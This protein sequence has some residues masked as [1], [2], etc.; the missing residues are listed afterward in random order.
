MNASGTPRR[1]PDALL[2]LAG[3]AVA[4]CVTLSL[5]AVSIGND[6]DRPAADTLVARIVEVLVAA[7]LLVAAAVC[8]VVERRLTRSGRLVAKMEAIRPT[9]RILAVSIAVAFLVCA[10]S[11]FG[12]RGILPVVRK[13][14]RAAWSP[15]RLRG[16]SPSVPMPKPWTRLLIPATACVLVEL[17]PTW[18]EAI[19]REARLRSSQSRNPQPR[20]RG[21]A[22][23]VVAYSV[24]GVASGMP[25][26]VNWKLAPRD[27]LAMGIT[28]VA[29]S[30]MFS[31]FSIVRGAAACGVGGIELVVSVVFAI[32]G[33]IWAICTLVLHLPLRVFVILI[34]LIVVAALVA[35]LAFQLLATNLC[36]S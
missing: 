12:F 11:L 8:G 18:V 13:T 29:G 2:V 3:T 19:D 36:P 10:F 23:V 7:L 14:R 4:G 1:L 26:V 34:T 6:C 15:Q 9:S 21:V 33:L 16:A 17:R 35:A 32:A 22:A 30:V 20:L 28:L 25:S 31:V 24:F 5:H 27:A